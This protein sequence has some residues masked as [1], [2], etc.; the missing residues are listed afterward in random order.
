MFDAIIYK[1]QTRPGPLIDI[2]ALAEGL[3]FYNRVAV[4]GSFG[5]FQY[6][7]RRV[8]PFV[9]LSLLDQQRIELD[10]LTEQLAIATM[11]ADATGR[12][13]HDALRFS[14]ADRSPERALPNLFLEAAGNTSQAKIA[15][16]RFTRQ[17]KSLDQSRFTKEVLLKTLA[18]DRSIALPIS[19]LLQAV[20]PEFSPSQD[21][22]FKIERESKGFYVDTNIDF[23][24]LNGLYHRSVSPQH[25]SLSEAYLLALVQG[26]IEATFFAAELMQRLLWIR[27][28][29][30]YKQAR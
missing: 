10:Y 20:V 13:L 6:L 23:D 8:P 24:A 17:V 1:N 22:R 9:L 16:R 18:D 25:S 4:V 12:A 5:T 27:S 15:A 3:L 29:R 30:L 11:P 14:S 28:R 2:G 7:L 21:T 26:A 19:S